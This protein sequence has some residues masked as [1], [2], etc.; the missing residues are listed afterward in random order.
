MQPRDTVLVLRRGGDLT[1]YRE[2]LHDDQAKTAC[3]QRVRAM[4]SAKWDVEAGSSSRQ[5]KAAADMLRDQ[6]GIVGWKGGTEKMLSGIL[7]GYAVA[8]CLWGRDGRQ[9]TLDRVQGA[10]LPPL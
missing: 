9:V 3:S 6:L 10:R 8:E 1:L 7:Y 2:L 5:D 4:A